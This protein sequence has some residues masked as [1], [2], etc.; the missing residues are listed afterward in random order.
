MGSA[1]TTSG[2]RV[3]AGATMLVLPLGAALVMWM[4]AGDVVAPEVS[5]VVARVP[6]QS[7]SRAEVVQPPIELD[8]PGY[9][10]VP[11]PA[12]DGLVSTLDDAFAS[13]GS[14]SHQVAVVEDAAGGLVGVSLSIDDGRRGADHPDGLLNL[15]A[16]IAG[17]TDLHL[18]ETSF[19][20]TR[21]FTGR[22]GE[23][24][25]LLWQRPAGFTMLVAQDHAAVQDFGR[26][27][28]RSL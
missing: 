4:T 5:K 10:F 23:D 25:I 11:Q 1:M 13:T 24:S 28:K 8:V 16:L 19:G 18:R 15:R 17:S 9:Q 14:G 26:A 22:H 6:G 20:N 7:D 3:A 2:G 27:L 21:V 12:D